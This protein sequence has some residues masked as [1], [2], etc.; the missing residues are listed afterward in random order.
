MCFFG[1][2]SLLLKTVTVLC[3]GVEGGGET[4]LWN[5]DRLVCEYLTVMLSK[6]T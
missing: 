5:V 2:Y 6:T 4:I 1:V 3:V